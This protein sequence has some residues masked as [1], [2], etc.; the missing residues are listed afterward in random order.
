M[1]TKRVGFWIALILAAAVVS[2]AIVVTRGE[3]RA[4]AQAVQTATPYPATATP[5]PA[6]AVPSATH[7]PTAVPTPLITTPQEVVVL[8]SPWYYVT[9]I[10]WTDW[11]AQVEGWTTIDKNGN[12]TSVVMPLRETNML[13]PGGLPVGE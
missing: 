8:S 9:I 6:T 3:Q 5:I 11:I 12:A 4:E 7:T 13:G 1:A 2:L 10:R